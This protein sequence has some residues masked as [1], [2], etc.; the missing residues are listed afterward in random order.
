MLLRHK[1]GTFVYLENNAL[2]IMGHQ[3]DSLSCLS[4]HFPSRATSVYKS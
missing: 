1:K 3:T 4:T 2:Q